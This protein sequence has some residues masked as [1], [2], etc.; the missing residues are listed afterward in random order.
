[1]SLVFWRKRAEGKRWKV[2]DSTTTL[3]RKGAPD[4]LNGAPRRCAPRLALRDRQ[5]KSLDASLRIMYACSWRALLHYQKVPSREAI[6]IKAHDGFHVGN[7]AGE[8]VQEKQ[9]M[10]VSLWWWT[11]YSGAS[12]A[13]T[14]PVKAWAFSTSVPGAPALFTFWAKAV[15]VLCKAHWWWTQRL[16]PALRISEILIKGLH[17]S[18]FVLFQ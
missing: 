7:E 5:G 15:C 8:S 2:R 12:A 13:S 10:P 3:H 11:L 17:L 6:F 16:D 18:E 1:M 9:R 14:G 4:P